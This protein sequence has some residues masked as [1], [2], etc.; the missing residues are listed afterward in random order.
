MK[1]FE[2][3]D[4]MQVVVR[5]GGASATKST[6]EGKGLGGGFAGIPNSVL[7]EANDH[8]GNVVTNGGANVEG[9]L[10]S[11]DGKISLA[12]VG[13]FVRE[14][15]RDCVC[16]CVRESVCVCVCERECVRERETVQRLP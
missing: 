1:A 2:T 15:E 13:E 10:I 6:A 5:T 11:V 9:Q 4:L 14:R 8:Y 3:D 12:C 16:V 7:V